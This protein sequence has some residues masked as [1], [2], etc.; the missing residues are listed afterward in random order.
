MRSVALG[1]GQRKAPDDYSP[2]NRGSGGGLGTRLREDR[3]LEYGRHERARAKSGAVFHQIA[4]RYIQWTGH[5]LNGMDTS[6]YR[7]PCN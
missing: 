6:H 4:G 2:G 1:I 3:W 5:F 7:N